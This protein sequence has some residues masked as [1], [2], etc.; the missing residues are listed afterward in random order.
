MGRH[1][2]GR[3]S[4]SP[5]PRYRWGELPCTQRRARGAVPRTCPLCDAVPAGSGR[6]VEG[7]RRR[8][9]RSPSRAR[10][11]RW[12]EDAGL[13]PPQ[14]G[15]DRALEPA[16]ETCGGL[17]R[18]L[19]TRGAAGQGCRLGQRRGSEAHPAGSRRGA[20][21]RG[22]PCARSHTSPAGCPSL[23]WDVHCRHVLEMFKTP[24]SVA[25]LCGGIFPECTATH[26]ASVSP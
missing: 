6:G 10:A 21:C 7:G 23:A 16:F 15:E 11:R 22:V 3:S 13:A 12:A 4:G 9:R 8:G 14:G 25:L 17:R 5:G 18:L 20:P 19:R 24:S 2:A 1:T 26:R